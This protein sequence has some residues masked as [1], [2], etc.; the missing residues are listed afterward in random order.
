MMDAAGLSKECV[1]PPEPKRGVRFFVDSMLCSFSGSLLALRS[2]CFTLLP[3]GLNHLLNRLLKPQIWHCSSRLLLRTRET[4]QR[5][6]RELP[7]SLQ[8]VKWSESS[9]FNLTAERRAPT[10]ADRQERLLGKLRRNCLFFFVSLAL[11]GWPH[12]I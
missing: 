2:A 12:G 6:N 10:A 3:F 11:L 1:Q 9:W 7:A 8:K 5:E 4:R